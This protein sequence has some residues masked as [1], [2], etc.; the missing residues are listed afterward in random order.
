MRCGSWLSLLRSAIEPAYDIETVTGY[1]NSKCSL[2]CGVRTMA[3]TD[4]WDPHDD[5]VWQETISGSEPRKVRAISIRHPTYPFPRTGIRITHIRELTPL[6]YSYLRRVRQIFQLPES[7]FDEGSMAFAEKPFPYIPLVWLPV[8]A[9]DDRASLSSFT[10]RHFGS[11][12]T[13]AIEKDRTV[14]LLA[15]QSSSSSD[16]GLALGSRAGIRI[17][18]HL[19]GGAQPPWNVRITSAVCSAD[20]TGTIND[21]PGF[22]AG[23]LSATINN[24]DFKS[25]LKDKLATAA[26]LAPNDELWLDGI[27]I[28]DAAKRVAPEAQPKVSLVIFGYVRRPTNLNGNAAYTL[29]ANVSVSTDTDERPPIKVESVE[30]VP[31]HAHATSSADLFPQDP[32][33]MAGLGKVIDARPNRSPERLQRFRL[34]T[35]LVGLASPHTHLIDDQG[36]VE[37]RQSKLVIATADEDAVEPVPTPSVVTHARTNAFAALGSYVHARGLFDKMRKFGFKPDQYFRLAALPLIVRYRATINQGHGPSDNDRHRRRRDSITVNAQVDYDPPA[38][39]FNSQSV[40]SLNQL[41]VRFALADLKR[42]G[43]K[44]E[45]LGL[46]ADPRWS[47]HE[48]GHVLLAASTG[49]LELRFAHS[50]G[51]ALAAIQC[52]PLSK[53]ALGKDGK[54][55]PEQRSRMFTFPWAGLSRY[56]QRSVHLGWGWSGAYHRPWRLPSA[57]AGLRHKGYDSEQILSTTLFRLYRALGGDT[58]HDD[59]TGAPDQNVRIAAAEYST[60]LIM[61]AISLLGPAKWVPIETP[62]QFV[63]VLIDA[64]IGTASLQQA[65]LADR[66]GGTAHK[67]VRWAFEAQGLYATLDPLAIVNAPGKPPMVDV[68]IENRRPP[69]EGA[70]P[71]GGY[72]PVS[73]DWNSTLSQPSWHAPDAAMQIRQDKVTVVVHNRG[74]KAAKHVVVQLWYLKWPLTDQI[75][76]QWDRTRWSS[77]PASPPATVAPGGSR[78]FGPFTGVPVAPG[79]YLILAA[80]SCPADRA[81]IDPVTMLPCACN[82]TPITD[83][84]AGDNNLGLRVLTIP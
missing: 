56:H 8:E 13:D 22:L 25:T 55:A 80:A 10:V 75:P 63:S 29:T 79:R 1:I 20:V 50:V 18:A 39:N 61:R 41:Q 57:A 3:E 28:L 48:Y 83:L 42:T 44:R 33:S 46:T 74:Q 51:D 11:L 58:V 78:P 68:F 81:N 67:I 64:D 66:V 34:S 15:V 19:D 26:G 9:G 30:R 16:P 35:K 77:I 60:Y 23:F 45:P 4:E 52:D 62:D 12:P 47:W 36:Q 65:P 43:S 17:V 53:L 38:A 6:A 71:R 37:V 2:C 49:E 31:L 7:L 14:V 32:A 27:R 24:N 76:P 5:A 54:L 73:L 82:P 70:F 21:G 59:G 40:T 72:M 84:V 69:S